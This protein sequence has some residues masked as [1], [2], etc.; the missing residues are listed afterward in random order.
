MST[1]A[2]IGVTFALMT[3]LASPAFSQT[4]SRS[5]LY[6][7]RIGAYAHEWTRPHSVHP[8]WEVYNTRGHYRGT[9]PDPFI[10]SQLGR[11]REC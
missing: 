2:I 10:R 1:K 5:G 4:A 3:M 8:G 11:C 6:D 7:H 9:D